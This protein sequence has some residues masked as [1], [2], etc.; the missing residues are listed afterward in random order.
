MTTMLLLA[1]VPRRHPKLIQKVPR[2]LAAFL[3]SLPFTS[4]KVEQS[5]NTVTGQL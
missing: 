4:K 2:R 3:M 5:A 1:Q